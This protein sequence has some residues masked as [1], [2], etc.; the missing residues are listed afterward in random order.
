V[1]GRSLTWTNQTFAVGE[2]KTFKLVLVVGS[3]VADGN[4]V[5]ST[6]SINTLANATVSNIA[7]ATVRV[8]PD[9]TFDCSDV[10]GKVFDDRNANGYQDD[11]EPG[12]PNVRL[13]T[14]RGLLVTTDADGRFHVPCADIPQ[15][16]HGSNFVMK[17]DER[18]LPSGYRV[19][20]ENP[21]DVRATRGKMV[22]LDFG[23]TV[24]KVFRLEVD[25]RAFAPA[26]DALLPEWNDRLKV[27]L[28]QLAQRPSVLR[29]AYRLQDGESPDQATRRIA[30][31]ESAVK[32][33][34]AKEKRGAPPL[35]IET[36]TV[37]AKVGGAK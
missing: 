9:P 36:E 10:I 17:L 12:I 18:T 4:Y 14:V 20:T 3:G 30:A 25:A 27:L 24:H 13:A 26:G 23:A 2:K 22:K 19:T 8:T 33:Q 5:N 15:M 34:Y 11:G 1:A 37:T 7:T 16:D 32:A 6:W 29:L 31:I 35:V 28:P 21:R